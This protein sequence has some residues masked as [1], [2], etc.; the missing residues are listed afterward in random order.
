[1]KS[2]Q[3]SDETPN[4]IQKNPMK[5]L[6]NTHKIDESLQNPYE[7]LSKILIKS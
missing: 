4:K 1:M 5:S 7:S 3:Q 6:K 2:P